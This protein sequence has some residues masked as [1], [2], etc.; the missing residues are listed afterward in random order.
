METE[1]HGEKPV[2]S[3]APWRDGVKLGTAPRVQATHHTCDQRGVAA[4]PDSGGTSL[5]GS[6]V[7]RA[8]L[9]CA[10]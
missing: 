2:T 6:G 1:V 10:L 8:L 5:S 4:K 3:G 7:H 9:I